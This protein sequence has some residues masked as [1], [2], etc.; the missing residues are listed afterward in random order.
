MY[1]CIHTYIHNIHTYIHTYINTY[2]H[3]H[4][5]IQVY[6]SDVAPG[7][8]YMIF[9]TGTNVAHEDGNGNASKTKSSG[10][11][12]REAATRNRE[13]GY[14]N[15]QQHGDDPNPGA[16]SR[17]GSSSS[18]SLQSGQIYA[19]AIT[20]AAV[21]GL[22]DSACGFECPNECSGHGACVPGGTCRCDPGYQAV[23]CSLKIMCHL[24]CSGH[25]ACDF[26]TA[27]CT[28]EPG[29]SGRGCEVYNCMRGMINTVTAP[30]TIAPTSAGEYPP[31]SACV[32]EIVPRSTDTLIEMSVLSM[33]LEAAE[34]VL[35]DGETT[36]G[37]IGDIVC[38]ELCPYDA[39]YIIEGPVTQGDGPGIPGM[40]VCVC[41]CVCVL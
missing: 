9:V 18:Q 11:P 5:H 38:W 35:G 33:Q 2:T 40:Y 37:C 34:A 20:G 15:G 36:A 31:N 7:R 19:L 14:E 29:F 41:V 26:L 27:M 8:K 24:N 28:C 6:I 39:L 12:N 1:V 13:H 17:Q 23:D 16:S 21:T 22:P 25:G 32:W 30:S 4:T 10:H 3:T